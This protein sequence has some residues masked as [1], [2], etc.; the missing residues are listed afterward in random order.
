MVV[1]GGGTSG[2]VYPALALAAV[3]GGEGVDILYVGSRTG[4]ERAL[5][6]DAGLPFEPL[7]VMGLERRI[8]WRNVV[9]GGKLAA[10]VG[11][12]VSILRRT[13]PDAVVVTGGYVGL[14]VAIAARLRHLPLVLHE[15][16]AV[17]GLSNRLAS[18][19]A[20]AVA[21]SFPGRGEGLGSR[22][23]VVGN[24]VRPEIAALGRAE[25]GAAARA[26]AIGHFG[27]ETGR[28]T[29][30]L[31]GGSQGARRINDA[32]LGSGGL[33]DRWR[34]DGRVQVLQLTGTRNAEGVEA[35]LASLRRPG[36]R[37]V[38][39]AL[40][41]TP[42]MDL[43]YALADLAVS[44]AGAS[45]IAELQA[46]AVPAV[47]VPYP[48]AAGDHQSRN[49]EVVERA[50]AAMAIADADLDAP[51]LAEVAER[52]LFDDEGRGRMSAAMRGL[53]RPEAAAS[54]AALVR[55]VATGRGRPARG[56]AG[57]E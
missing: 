21:L 27:L 11:R 41:Y 26:D 31:T 24:P 16:N 9:A 18:R 17:L 45:T 1:A 49:A 54:L 30:L 42:R 43:A 56:I 4:P 19:F 33:Y 46:A 15:Q 44:R 10:S 5:A 36:D 13:R 6:A 32:A 22:A 52:L 57:L 14:P 55:G 48:F 38:W 50:G 28:R 20:D 2:H 34:S 7:D 37:I 25:A 8:G 23:H 29:L 53:A 40:P 35:A 39:H 51:R 3:L 47:L 12:C